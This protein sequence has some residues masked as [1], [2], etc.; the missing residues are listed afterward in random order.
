MIGQISKFYEKGKLTFFCLVI[1]VSCIFLL[2]LPRLSIPVVIAYIFFLIINPVVPQI[3]KLGMRRWLAIAVIFLGM[4][5]FSVYPIV[6]IVPVIKTEAENLQYNF[7][8]VERYLKKKYHEFRYE[9]KTRTGLEL[10]DELLGNVLVYATSSSKKI[11]LGIPQILASILEWSIVAPLFLFFFLKDGRKFRSGLLRL[12]PNFVFERFYYLFNE[13]NKKIGDYIFA[14]FVEASIIGIIT[15]SG[16]LFM[17]VRF[18]FLLGIIAAVTN[19]IPYIGPFLGMIPAVIWGLVEYGPASPIFGGIVI[20]FMVANI[21]DLS[22]VFPI[23]VSKIV[24]LHPIVVVV[25]V[26]LGSHYLGVVGMVISIPLATALKL[27]FLQIYN[28]IYL[29]KSK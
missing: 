19:I 6:K 11:L 2:G 15:T 12:T 27:I 23:L 17:G 1:A 16:L 21:I 25:S 22:L 24:N 5:G 13:F 8:K 29:A 20:L 26:I 10:K 7:P 3:M 9:I 28:E 14:K 4:A 18:S